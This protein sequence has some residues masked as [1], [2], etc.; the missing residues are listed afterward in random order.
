MDILTMSLP[1]HVFFFF[2]RIPSQLCFVYPRISEPATI[3]HHNIAHQISQVGPSRRALY[4]ALVWCLVS[5]NER[6]RPD[7]CDRNPLGRIDILYLYH[8][9]NEG[10]AMWIQALEDVF[11]IEDEDF[12]V[13]HVSIVIP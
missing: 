8:A 9:V 5:I 2:V 11:Q 10:V 7:P 3:R 6:T 4:P 1:S 12:L 13:S